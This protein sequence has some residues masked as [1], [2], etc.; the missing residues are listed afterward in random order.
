MLLLALVVALRPDSCTA[1]SSGASG[2][3]LSDTNPMAL[4][5]VGSYGLRALSPTLLELTLINSKDPEPSAIQ[6]WNFVGANFTPNLPPASD[7]V[8]TANGTQVSIAQVGFKRRPIYAAL[9]QRDLRIGNHLYLKLST[10]IA[11]GAKVEVKNPSAAHW[12]TAKN[13][14][15]TNEVLRFNPAIHVNQ[16]GYM[17]SGPKKAMVGYY[18]GSMGEMDIPAAGGFKI[19]NASSGAVVF[20]GSLTVRRDVGYTYTPAPYT[21]VYE[22]D[23]SAFTTPGEYRLHVPG[24]GASYSFM[25]NEGTFAAF[26][27][28]FALGM[29]HQR[30]GCETKFPFTRHEHEACHVA[31][32]DVPT[33]AFTFTQGVLAD[34]SSDFANEPRHTAP[35]LKNIESSLYP[36]VR[37]GKVD[38]NRGHHDAGDYSKY[39]INSAGLIHHL[40]F[41]ADSFAGAGGLDNLGLPESGDGKSDLLQEAKWEAD[42]L[43]KMQDTDGGFYFLVYPKDRRYEDTVLPDAGDP[44]VVWPKTTAV[45]AAAVA[46]LAEIGSSPRFKQQFPAEAALYMTKA[47]LGW[48]FL[49][50]AIERHGKDGAYQKLTHYGHEFMHDDELAWAAAAMFA[51]TGNQTYHAKLKEFMP[52]PNSPSIRRWGWWK[53]FE[54]W[55]GAIRTYAFAARSGRLA[56]AALDSSYLAKCDAEIH[57]LAADHVRF[58]NMSS[59]GTSFPDLNKAQRTAGWYFSSERAFDITVAYQLDAR[60]DY[61]EAVIANINYEGGSNPVNQPH[62]TGLG[63]KRQREIVHQY[64]QNDR[65]V[66]PPSGIPQG[67]IQAG[68]ASIGSYQGQLTALTFPGDN[69]GTAPY[70][71]YD[72]WADHFNTTAEFVVVDLARSLGSL[73]F[74]MAQSGVASQSWKSATGTVAGLPATVAADSEATISFSVPGVDLNGAQVVW[75]ITNLDPGAGNPY[76]FS[77]KFA[78]AHTI[79]VEAMLPD[80]RRI[81]AKTN[82][83]ATTSLNT[84]PNGFQSAPV[85]PTA[86]TVA[87]YHLDGNLA[88]AA[89]KQGPLTLAGNAKLDNS[90]LAWMATRA[91]GTLEFN[92]LADRA[93]VSIPGNALISANTGFIS[94]EAM[95]YVN[96]FKAFNRGNAKILSLEQSWNSYM[97]LYEDMYQGPFVKGGTTFSYSGAELKNALTVKQ[98]HHLRISLDRNGYVVALNGSPLRT[99]ASADLANWNSTS[100]VT[101]RLGDFDGWIDEVVIKSS[102]AAPTPMNTPPAVTLSVPAGPYTAPANVSLNATATDANGTVA[103][104]EFFNGATKL[105]EDAAA[106]FSYTWTG[107]A[108]GTYTVTAKATDNEGMSTTSAPVTVTVSAPTNGGGGGGGGEGSPSASFLQTDTTTKGNWSGVYGSQGYYVI[109][110]ASSAPAYGSATPSGHQEYIWSASTT[111]ARALQKVAGTDRVCA[112]WYSPTTFNVNVNFTDNETHRVSVYMMDWD[113]GGRS[114]RVEV[115]DAASG[116]VLNT[117]SVSDFAQG[118]YVSW[119]IKGSVRLRFTRT[120]GSNAIVE[121]VFFDAATANPSEPTLRPIGRDGNGRFKFAVTGQAGVTYNIQASETMGAWTNVGQLAMTNTTSEFTDLSGGGNTLK[122]YRAR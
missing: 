99:A 107:V 92:D 87:L 56:A 4:P 84:P 14:V 3:P 38:V 17:P 73:A 68:S 27:R 21:K 32:A 93:T 52:D 41:A 47:T 89:G 85:T 33:P 24:L 40:V 77:P 13:F 121:G 90:N 96:E 71:Y 36:F 64:A 86:E 83:T 95:I 102:S 67:N 19:V 63:W 55:G 65:R 74:W 25:I 31:P 11:D 94:I 111:D 15:T 109:G 62:I 54:G 22:A 49:M 100:P 108:A 9:K 53:M 10:P 1:Q 5:E 105:G 30:C 28:T 117:V 69:V 110:N 39:T 8:V 58:S 20:S 98:W 72:R 44:Q 59:Y 101:L 35:Q 91:G 70:P 113:N 48:T 120:A 46:A 78:G 88:D 34:V 82:F 57:A 104:V 43:A 119:N 23:F 81:F 50:T 18:L 6:S 115:I 16:V 76:K 29:F 103:K 26:A 61:R 116:A 118:K 122:F 45:T 66:L 51:A 80:G 7:F 97:E 60:A 2:L 37:Q 79:E 75:E 112:V 106:P 42:Y 12:P 114:Q